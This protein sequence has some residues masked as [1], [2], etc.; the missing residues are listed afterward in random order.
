MSMTS[1]SLQG[2]VAQLASFESNFIHILTQA[3]LKMSEVS[4]KE[5][6]LLVKSQ[7]GTYFAGS[8][9]LCAAYK[10][11]T[12]MPASPDEVHIKKAEDQCEGMSRISDALRGF[13]VNLWLYLR[14]INFRFKA[15]YP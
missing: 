5:L 8:R 14:P 13:E 1:T 12:L 2:L 11:G 15:P 3:A 4:G 6:F 10:L 9:D 7:T